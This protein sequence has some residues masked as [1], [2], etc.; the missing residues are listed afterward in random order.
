MRTRR[1]AMSRALSFFRILCLTGGASVLAL[2]CLAPLMAGAQALGGCTAAA[3]GAFRVEVRLDTA[4]V[5]L[6]RSLSRAQLGERTF[7]GPRT[8]VL[9]LT[10]STVD[11]DTSAAYKWS[12]AGDGA[13]FWVEAVDVVLRYQAVE[14]FVASEYSPNSCAYH[15]ILRHEQEHVA[16]ARKHLDRYAPRYRAA[17]TSLLI[18]RPRSP[19]LVASQSEMQQE[20]ERLLAKLLQPIAT[21][22]HREMAEAQAA[23]DTPQVYRR[24]RRQCK[25]W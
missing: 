23:L 14:I 1:E 16:V 25:N 21:E 9:G 8:R 24:V 15:A 10:H 17:L 11:L 6:N 18:P 13:C 12:P 19:K 22:M 20:I 2:A 5:R 3:G 4:P 7:H